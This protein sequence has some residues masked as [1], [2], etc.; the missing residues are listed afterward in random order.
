MKKFISTMLS[1]TLAVA[2]ALSL[3]AC[4]QTDTPPANT[5]NGNNSGNASNTP[6]STGSDFPN[7]TITILVGFSAGSG[8]DLGA[9]ILANSLSKELGVPVVVENAPGS[10]SWIVWNQLIKNTAADGYTL[11]AINHNYALGAYDPDT[12]REFTLDD[13][14]LLASQAIDPNLMAIRADE[15]RFTDFPSFVE[16]AQNNDVFVAVQTVGIT[17]GDATMTEW[18]RTEFDCKINLV[19]VDS[20]SDGR[21][22]FIA[23]D[24]DVYFASVG[25]V[26]TYVQ[27]GTMK[28][29]VVFNSER[30]SFL[31]DVPTI[32]DLGYDSS[33]SA[34]SA[35]GYACPKGTDPAVVEILTNAIVKAM[36]SE[37]HQKQLAD[38]GVQSWITTGDEFYDLLES[39]LTNRLKIWNI[40][41]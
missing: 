14:T 24:V 9:R 28:A 19:P 1:I 4:G 27:E 12:P 30:S 2:M 32:Y 37:D 22:M 3:S 25:D 29:T 26:Y 38:L 36:E 17:D 10:G 16:Y 20:A 21:T 7:G 40:E 33:I 35:R 39:Q 6:S 11:A 5:N 8:T 31:P 15:T 18:L 41:S 23:G 34:F 13:V